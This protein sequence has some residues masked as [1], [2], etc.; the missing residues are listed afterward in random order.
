M[1]IKNGIGERKVNME[2]L[3]SIV[4]RDTHGDYKKASKYDALE[5]EHR[6]IRKKYDYLVNQQVLNETKI[7]EA[8]QALVN[9]QSKQK[10]QKKKYK[11]RYARMRMELQ[12]EIAYLRAAQHKDN[13]IYEV[14][15]ELPQ[16]IVII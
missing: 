14:K 8:R 9:S 12:T 3:N 4:I 5:K 16:Y 1:M 6:E 2:L 13:Y 11:E 10:R 15:K 7:Y